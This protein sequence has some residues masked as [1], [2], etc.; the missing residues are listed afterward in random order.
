[1]SNYRFILT[2]L[3]SIFT[4][5]HGWSQLYMY[6]QLN[7]GDGI[8]Y[9]L[10]NHPAVTYTDAELIVRTESGITN[11]YSISNIKS[12]TYQSSTATILEDNTALT[13]PIRIYSTFGQYITTLERAEDLHTSIPL[14]VYI[15]RSEKA[16]KKILLP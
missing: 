5:W 11:Q 7:D 8:Y 15:L 2:W 9:Q 12:I 16:S 10:E 6:I 3:F 4:I 14:G 13:F 1:M